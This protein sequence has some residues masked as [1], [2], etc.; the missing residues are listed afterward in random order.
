MNR[1]TNNGWRT[2]SRG[3]KFR[4]ST[5]CPI[6]WKGNRPERAKPQAPRRAR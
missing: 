4:G 3:H 1:S 6:C 2:C 5:A